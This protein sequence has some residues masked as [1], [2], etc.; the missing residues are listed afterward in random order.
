MIAAAATAVAMT[1]WLI[2][3]T[4]YGAPGPGPGAELARA[5][6]PALAGPAQRDGLATD[7]GDLEVKAAGL[8]AGWPSSQAALLGRLG[9]PD[10][11]TARSF[12]QAGSTTAMTSSTPPSA[13]RSRLASAG[14]PKLSATSHEPGPTHPQ[15]HPD[16]SICAACW[17]T[18]KTA[19][20]TPS[21]CSRACSRCRSGMPI[22]RST[23]CA[24]QGLSMPYGPPD[25]SMRADAAHVRRLTSSPAMEPDG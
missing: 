1:C 22:G 16:G 23:R 17:L 14:P 19:R 21:N 5:D 13:A 9:L 24:E 15:Q 25:T 11:Q 4:G 3:T 2:T 7:P 10:V 6:L 18:S 8:A 12:T 20:P